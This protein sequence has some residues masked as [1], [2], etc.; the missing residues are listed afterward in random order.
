MDLNSLIIIEKIDK[1]GTFSAAAK[2]L[3]MPNSNLSLKVK[4]LE[5]DL[6]QPLFARS[7]RQVFITEFGRMVLSEAKQILEVKGRIEALAEESIREP[8]GAMRITASYDVGLYLLRS[9]IPRF[10]EEYKKIQVEIDLSN[11]RAD[12]ITEGYDLAIRATSA[13]LAD[14]SAVA[15]KLSSTSLRLYAHKNSTY[16]K[17]SS[18]AELEK[19]PILSMASE[20]KITKEGDFKIL[21]PKSRILVKDMTG[22]KH[23]ILGM[24]GVGI[25]P[26]YIC[27]DEYSKKMLINLFPEWTAGKGVFYAVYPHK[28]S[29]TPKVR[30]FVDFLKEQFTLI[31]RND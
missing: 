19:V 15:V 2:A 7:T 22:I 5:A 3:K 25:I 30:V 9:I 31:D 13:R 17:I 1:L 12:I 29:L 18:I 14:S 21:Y 27:S 28:S 24:A 6:G 10:S 4:Q 26:E 23:A 16:A 8:S 20:V 11:A